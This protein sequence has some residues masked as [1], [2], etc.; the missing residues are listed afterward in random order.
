MLETCRR[1]AVPISFLL[2]LIG[3]KRRRPLLPASPHASVQ[4]LVMCVYLCVCVFLYVCA[5]VYWLCAHFV[6]VYVCCAHAHAHVGTSTLATQ[7]K[8]NS[9]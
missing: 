2:P 3:E 1:V 4:C 7:D 5:G 9:S 8:R 6:C